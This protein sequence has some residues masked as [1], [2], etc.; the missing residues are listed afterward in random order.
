M[1]KC[2]YF[3]VVFFLLISS[4]VH[5][6]TVSITM[7]A[8]NCSQSGTVGSVGNLNLTCGTFS[9]FS[10]EPYALFQANLGATSGNMLFEF[11]SLHPDDAGRVIAD[12]NLSGFMANY[13]FLN[14]QG[15]FTNLA[16]QDMSFSGCMMFTE[17]QQNPCKF[18]TF[19]EVPGEGHFL[20]L[21]IDES[22]SFNAPSAFSFQYSIDYLDGKP[23]PEPSSVL[24]LSSAFV[25]LVLRRR[26]R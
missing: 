17:G 19:F 15:T 13:G 14:W 25:S 2:V 10:H 3:S 1:N 8:G 24:L 18:G 16:V 4:A 23:V 6:D 20:S 9:A 7:Q 5:A 12:I 11:F 22:A 21:H 26:A